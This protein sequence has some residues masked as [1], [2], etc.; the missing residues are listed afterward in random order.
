MWMV[1]M[2]RELEVIKRPIPGDDEACKLLREIQ[3]RIDSRGEVTLPN[4]VLGSLWRVRRQVAPPTTPDGAGVRHA[5]E[6]ERAA[7]VRRPKPAPPA[8]VS[9]CPA[10]ALHTESPSGYLAWHSWAAAMSK[11]HRQRRCPS[12]ELWAIWEPKTPRRTVTP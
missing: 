7:F 8:P 2:P 3:G 10:Q 1:L 9:Q 6:G 5:F 12:C 4:G 11:T